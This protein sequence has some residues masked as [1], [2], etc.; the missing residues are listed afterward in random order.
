MNPGGNKEPKNLK[1]ELV[2][3]G[4]GGAGLAAAVAAAEKGASNVMVLEKRNITGG[5][6]AMAVGPF[7]A[8]SPAQRRQAIIASRDDLFKRA[9]SWAHWKINPRIVRAFIDRSGDTI[10]WLEEKGLHFVLI[11][12]SLKDMPLTWHVPKGEGRELMEVLARECERLKVQ[13]LTRAPAKKILTGKKGNVTGVLAEKE[14]KEFT[15]T[16]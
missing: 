2:I 5:N 7:A 16:T 15:I 10:R 14:G 13:L 3:I 9:M 12:H 11:A 8:E 1:A 6:S 4:G